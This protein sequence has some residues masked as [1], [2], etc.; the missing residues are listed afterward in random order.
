VVEAGAGSFIVVANEKVS[1]WV[2]G[3]D[4]VNDW[5]LDLPAGLEE[6]GVE[7]AGYIDGHIWVYGANRLY[8]QELK[9]ASE[10]SVSRIAFTSSEVRPSRVSFSSPLEGSAG[11]R[12]T[13]A[14]YT[15]QSEVV[16]SALGAAGIAPRAKEGVIPPEVP[17]PAASLPSASS[18]PPVV[19][20][21]PAA[22]PKTQPPPT[23]SPP[24]APSNA[25][26]PPATLPPAAPSLPP[27][28]PAVPPSAPV[29]GPVPK[30]PPNYDSAVK[31]VVQEF[32]VK[33]HSKYATR[34]QLDNDRRR[35]LSSV[36]SG[37]MPKGAT[38][39]SAKKTILLDYVKD[40]ISKE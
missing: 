6:K 3:K 21:P 5:T 16:V 27:A 28:S 14:V 8:A 1:G 30:A 11:F 7:G 38:M 26:L 37:S 32:C 35:I 13:R 39:S 2:V 23:T 18:L 4:T 25:Q 9:A 33:C 36:E 40:L 29:A 24:T 34:A 17:K 19:A 10:W 15:T 12:P 22:P 31:P 20:K